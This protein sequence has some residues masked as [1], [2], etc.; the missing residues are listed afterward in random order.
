MRG[1]P[2][3]RA[4]LAF[5]S[6]RAGGELD[7][8]VRPLDAE[9]GEPVRL[10]DA[11][12]RDTDPDFSADGTQIVFRSWRKGGGVWV[13]PSAGGPA[14][15]LAAGGYSPRF[16]PKGDWV[17]Y[18][19]NGV[20]VIAAGGGSARRIDLGVRNPRSPVW[21]PDGSSLLYL[22]TGP[23]GGDDWWVTRFDPGAAA[24][25]PAK[26]MGF[27]WLSRKHR[28]VLQGE[29]AEPEDWVE[30]AVLG[31]DWSGIVAVPVADK[32][33]RFA[34]MP[35]LLQ[36]GPVRWARG[37]FR[38][39]QVIYQTSNPR[40]QTLLIA[41]DGGGAEQLLPDQFVLNASQGTIT[42]FSRDGRTFAYATFREPRRH[43]RLRRLADGIETVMPTIYGYRDLRPVVNSTAS[44][45]AFLRRKEPEGVNLL[46]VAPVSGGGAGAD[47]ERS[48]VPHSWSPDD[49]FLLWSAKKGL[50]ALDT[51]R[52]SSEELLP[53]SELRVY[54]AVFSPDG[55]WV[56]LTVLSGE[57]DQ[58]DGYVAP[59]R[60]PFPPRAAWI[61]MT[62]ARHVLELAWSGS[63]DALYYLKN[64][65][66]FRDLWKQALDSSMRPRGEPKVLRHF[67][68]FQRYPMSGGVLSSGGGWI[69]VTVSSEFS[70]IWTSQVRH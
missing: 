26:A 43:I 29:I 65:D 4:T 60:V 18:I 2:R 42:R 6:D 44:A 61:P 7:I 9:Q 53:G 52:G 51:R 11:P 1:R 45:V 25:A 48:G 30:G 47:C 17:A 15:L 27:G 69:S 14:R 56:A 12:E 41:E 54:S 66:G 32:P 49:R 67:H 39:Q 23:D 37:G 55:K 58:V 50:K 10:T 5:A 20:Q 34:G 63:G 33:P 13:V 57:G 40:S 21:S 28:E 16:S 35:T 8:W 24:A 64:T 68:S 19:N 62:S 38:L 59:F 31:L 36:S 70:E 22:A 3:S 46:C